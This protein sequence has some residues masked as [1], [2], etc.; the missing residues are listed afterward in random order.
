ML[1]RNS[2]LTSASRVEGRARTH[3]SHASRYSPQPRACSLAFALATALASASASAAN[4]EFAPRISAAYRYNDNYHLELPGGEIEVS[5]GEADAALTLRTVDPRTRIELTPRVRATYFPDERDEDSND[6]FFTALI[7]DETPRRRTG[8]G[9]EFARED[10]VRSEFPGADFDG[11]LGEPQEDDSGQFIEKNRR[12]LIRLAPYFSY[13]VSQRYRLD[14]N[15]QYIDANYDKNILG[16]QQDFSE[17]GASV[18]AGIKVSPRST[19]SLSGVAS[20][21]ETSIEADAYGGFL[22]WGTDVSPTSH[23]YVRAGAQQTE[24]DN[25]ESDTSWI[26]GIGGQWESERNRLFLDFTRTVGPVAAGTIVER[27]QL[28]FRLGH[29][30]SERMSTILGARLR[31]DEALSDLSTYPTREYAAAEVGLEWRM[32]RQWSLVATY[33]YRW[34]E[35]EDEPSDAS[36]NG[37]LLGVVYEPKRA[38]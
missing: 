12:D 4:W 24:S 27:H 22:Q 29:D 30:I 35:Y 36:A 32:L 10:V 15:A 20:R 11:G 21:Y 16:A 25:G 2:E 9:A 28:R 34:Q 5:G 38:E 26:G 1:Y 7:G 23:V 17:L 37:F 6:Y 33:N 19:L 8:L 31:R 18:G 14:L 13:D 3:A